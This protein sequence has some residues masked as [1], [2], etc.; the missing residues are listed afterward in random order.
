MD[1][2]GYE[3]FNDVEDDALRTRNRDAC[4]WN[5]YESN[6]KAG[7]TTP[8][9]VADMVGYIKAIPQ[10]DQQVVINKLSTFIESG[11]VA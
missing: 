4:L 6:T 8:N 1:Y 9:G 5:I 3:L 10:E 7:R 2:K 11:G